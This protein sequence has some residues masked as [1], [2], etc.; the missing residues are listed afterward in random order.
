MKEN[1]EGERERS[2]VAVTEDLSFGGW[3][4]F[5]VEMLKGMELGVVG[6]GNGR[7]GKYEIL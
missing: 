1:G 3:K 4:Y 5:D 2:V 7:R 6:R